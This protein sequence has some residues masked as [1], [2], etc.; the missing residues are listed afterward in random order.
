MSA[1]DAAQRQLGSQE[2]LLVEGARR[3]AFALYRGEEVPHHACG[4]A[5]AVTFGV[6]ARP[7]QSLRKGGITGERFCGSIRAGEL[8]LGELLGDEDPTGSV[9]SALREAMVWYQA[10]IPSRFDKGE[11]PDYVCN[12]L[13]VKLGDFGGAARKDFCTSLTGEVA[14][15]TMEAVLRFAPE[16]AGKLDEVLSAQLPGQVK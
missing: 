9:T 8:L 14:A 11:S 1:T 6:S 4:A 15:L 16:L 10:Q 2:N 7:Y 13:T 5:V 3:R 12:N